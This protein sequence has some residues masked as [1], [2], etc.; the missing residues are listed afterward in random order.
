MR[1][2]WYSLR[3]GDGGRIR[4]ACPGHEIRLSAKPF[5][6]AAARDTDVLVLRPRNSDPVDRF[7]LD[8][9]PSL[10]LIATMSTGVDH[11]A[12]DACRERKITVS[13]VQ[14]YSDRS[15]VE[16]VFALIF[17]LARITRSPHE[18]MELSGK[19]LGVVG[20]GA[21]GRGVLQLGVA[22]GMEAVASDIVQDAE[23]A[24]SVGF[25]YIELDEL[26]GTSD[27]ISLHAPLL[28]STRHLLNAERLALLKRGAILINTAR[29]GLVDT[30]ALLERLSTGE[31][32]AGLDVLSI[33]GREDAWDAPEMRRLL[34]R[35]NVI[36]SPHLAAST[37]EAR[38]RA[39]AATMDTV[40]RFVEK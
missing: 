23:M 11:I 14:G 19:R 13:S 38:E 17:S 7:V 10:Q 1:I 4:A 21:I 28:E 33:D 26:L 25:T 36:V 3:D 16:Y 27:I 24:R 29:G 22:Y 5:T 39:F 30:G 31:V 37:V 2:D 34:A 40:R 9:M 15:V 20:A 12:I 6:H 18:G 35:P 8:R 32:A